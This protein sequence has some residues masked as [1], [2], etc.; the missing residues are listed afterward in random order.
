LVLNRCIKQI[1]GK[2]LRKARVSY[3]FV[4]YA[5]AGKGFSLV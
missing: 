3:N 4:Y 5:C 2:A 1:F